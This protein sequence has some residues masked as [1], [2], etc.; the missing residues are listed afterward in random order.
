VAEGERVECEPASRPQRRGH[1]FEDTS[2]FVPAAQVEERAVRDVDERRRLVE[3]EVADVA[4]AQTSPRRSSSGNPALRCRATS[5]IAG[6]ESI[7][8]R[9]FPV[10][11]T[12]SI[13]TR[14]VPT[15]SST[16][17]PSASRARS[18]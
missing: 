12:T 9:G 15:I 2:L 17:G 11:R 14:P 1:P 16:I 6:D 4:E 18:T 3:L 13:A 7:P 10:A 8:S 5:S